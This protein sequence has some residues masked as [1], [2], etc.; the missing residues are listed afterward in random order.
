MAVVSGRPDHD[1]FR[2]PPNKYQTVSLGRKIL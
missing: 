1:K 2:S